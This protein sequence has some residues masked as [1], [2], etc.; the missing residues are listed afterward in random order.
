MKTLPPFAKMLTGDN[1]KSYATLDNL[2]TALEKNDLQNHR[3][4]L[5]RTREGRFTAIILGTTA[6]N[7]EG[8]PG[9]GPALGTGF[10]I[11]S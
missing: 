3:M 9:R 8:T 6:I 10:L 1:V 5:T 2:I 11:A 4:V 7:G